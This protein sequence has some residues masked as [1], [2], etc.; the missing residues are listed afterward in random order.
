[1]LQAG[2]RRITEGSDAEAMWNAEAQLEKFQRRRLLGRGLE[3][4]L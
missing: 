2:L 1:M 4:K 3:M